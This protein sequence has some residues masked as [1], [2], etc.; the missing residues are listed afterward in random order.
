MQHI[1]GILSLL[2]QGKSMREALLKGVPDKRHNGLLPD[3]RDLN[4]ELRIHL[5]ERRRIARKIISNSQKHEHK[6][7]R[8]ECF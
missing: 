8:K 1:L 2:H 6:K 7:H 3:H 4:P 5:I